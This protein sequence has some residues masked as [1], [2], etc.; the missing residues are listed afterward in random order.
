MHSFLTTDSTIVVVL[1]DA[2]DKSVQWLQAF[3]FGGSTSYETQSVFLV[4]TKIDKIVSD[5]MKRKSEEVRSKLGKT[6]KV[7]STSSFRSVV[8]LCAR[9][10]PLAAA[11]R[12]TDAFSRSTATA[13]SAPLQARGSPSYCTNS[14]PCAAV[15]LASLSRRRT[16]R[17]T[18]RR[19]QAGPLGSLIE[20]LAASCSICN[21]CLNIVL[22]YLLCSWYSYRHCL[23]PPVQHRASSAGTTECGNLS[24]RGEW[25]PACLTASGPDTGS[26]RAAPWPTQHLSS[27]PVPSLK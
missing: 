24:H 3:L 14:L 21:K 8:R 5:E 9:P 20:L 17:L 1:F 22:Q 27:A 7:L 6:Q 23:C 19:E 16:I 12:E 4:E 18:S 13:A 25:R 10:E 2:S 15:R 11:A 26:T